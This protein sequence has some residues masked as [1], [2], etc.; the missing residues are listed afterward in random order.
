[1]TPEDIKELKEFARQI[2][3]LTLEQVEQRKWWRWIEELRKRDDQLSWET[4]Q[5][6]IEDEDALYR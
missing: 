5:D 1:M 2:A 4:Q 6:Y 3:R